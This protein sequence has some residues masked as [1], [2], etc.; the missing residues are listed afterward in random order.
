MHVDLLPDLLATGSGAELTDDQLPALVADTLG[1]SV[2]VPNWPPRIVGQW[3]RL[4]QP[5]GSQRSWCCCSVR[6]NI[7]AAATLAALA[8]IVARREGHEPSRSEQEIYL[9]VIASAIGG[10]STA[11]RVGYEAA[12]YQLLDAGVPAGVELLLASPGE[13]PASP[14]P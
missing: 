7:P 10:L 9:P 5:S 6:S 11:L 2:V 4:G 1:R 13:T 8:S 12:A 14:P 3:C